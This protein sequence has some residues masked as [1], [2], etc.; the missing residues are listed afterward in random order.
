MLR[1][2]HVGNRSRLRRARAA[3]GGGGSR[4]L[5]SQSSFTYLGYHNLPGDLP[6]NKS[7]Y[8]LG[9]TVRYRDG[10]QRLIVLDYASTHYRPC[11]ITLTG[12]PGSGGGATVGT[13]WTNNSQLW[14]SSTLAAA[15]ATTQHNGIHWEDGVGLWWNATGDY[16]Q[17]PYT[18][19][20]TQVLSLRNLADDGTASGFRGF[21]SLEG[22]GTRGHYG[23]MRRAPAW[24]VSAHS[25][26]RPYMSGWGGYSSLYDQGLGASL[27]LL[28]AFLPDPRDYVDQPDYYDLTPTIPEED[29]KLACDVRTGNTLTDWYAGGFNS[30]T[31][32]RGIRVTT[33][34]LT[35]YNAGAVQPRVSPSTNWQ[36][37]ASSVGGDPLYPGRQDWGDSPFGCLDWIDNDAGDRGEHGIVVEVTVNGGDAWYEASSLHNEDRYVERHLYDPADVAAVLAGSLPPWKLRPYAAWNITDEINSIVNEFGGEAAGN[38][39]GAFVGA[40]FDPVVNRRYMLC[41]VPNALN[42]TNISRIHVWGVAA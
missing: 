10:V 1:L 21:F 17:A 4:T 20:N 12:S 7:V 41:Q 22:I 36:N 28:L 5:L 39:S 3:S 16:P 8:A 33:D 11:E 18:A 26:G 24:F 6:G 13:S 15:G 29:F 9:P 2:G 14:G 40:C 32:D 42:P 23:G 35:F 34:Y 38:E 25:P 37:T 19:S 31:Y 30:R 27:G